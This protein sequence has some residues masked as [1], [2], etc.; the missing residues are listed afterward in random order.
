M[1]LAE[2]LERVRAQPPRCI[3]VVR[4]V[5]LPH[6]LLGMD[7]YPGLA[8]FRIGCPCR[9]GAAFILGHW[10][11]N[12]DA[13]GEDFFTG[14]LAIECP[15]CG[16][17]SEFMDPEQHGYDGEIGANT[18]T[19]GHGQ[20]SRFSCSNCAI[21]TPMLAMPGFS[22]KKIDDW[23]ASADELRR[24]QDFFGAF[25]LYGACTQCRE[26]SNVVGFECA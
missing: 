4:P 7:R 26:L 2:V 5:P 23:H 8:Y 10:L 24:P 13:P 11:H 18:T 1:E 25:W 19:V 6:P 15:K 17:V 12:E 20:R 16:R 22:Y 21:A 9:E 3:T 14:P